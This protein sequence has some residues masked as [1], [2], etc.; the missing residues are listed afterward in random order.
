MV[1]D[2]DSDRDNDN[3]APRAFWLVYILA[4]LALLL[5]FV[6]ASECKAATDNPGHVVV[7]GDRCTW[8]KWSARNAS[9]TPTAVTVR[10]FR[11]MLGIQDPM[12]WVS[13]DSAAFPEWHQVAVRDLV[14]C[15]GAAQLSTPT[16]S[17]LSPCPASRQRH[18]RRPRHR[19]PCA[20]RRWGFRARDSAPGASTAR[21]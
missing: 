14:E 5:Y 17:R 8:P 11:P 12:A 20:V 18:Q 21:T 13:L 10:A 9:Y 16:T 1:T 7:E 6:P 4:A 19:K 15:R 3:G 2:N